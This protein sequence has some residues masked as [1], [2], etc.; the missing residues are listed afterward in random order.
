[1][2]RAKNFLSYKSESPVTFVD[3]VME[4]E[5]EINTGKVYNNEEH[6]FIGYYG[7]LIPIE[8]IKMQEF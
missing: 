2:S 3:Y 1:M 6:L 5:L 7:D 4:M 8:Q